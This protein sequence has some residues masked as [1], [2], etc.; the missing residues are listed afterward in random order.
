M[1]I[2]DILLFVISVALGMQMRRYEGD[3]LMNN[4]GGPRK[5]VVMVSSSVYG[6][7]ELLDRIYTLLTAFNYEVWMSHKG[8]MPVSSS[9]SCF[10]NCLAAVEK[11]D[12]FL[13]LITTHYGS[14]KESKNGLSITHRELLRAIELKKPRWILVHD[15]VVFARTLLAN[16]VT[17]DK[18]IRP[19]LKLKR[20]AVIDDLQVIDMYDAVVSS[21]LPIP[22]R[23]G[24]W[25]QKYR[26]S[27]DAMLYATAQ[28]SRYQEVEQF[29]QEN[30][31]DEPAVRA[32]LESGHGRK[33]GRK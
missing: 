19:K 3:T 13:G 7:E 9:R 26:T 5:L 4:K 30:L 17:P 20:N 24:N 14:G 22:A 32:C 33:G 31:K 16:L 23:K 25:A 11:C 6:I 27:E 21:G 2:V 28:F 18:G 15:H 8:T 29:V 1:F 10:D 12:L